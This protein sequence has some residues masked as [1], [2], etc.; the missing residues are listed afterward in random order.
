MAKREHLYPWAAERDYMRSLKAMIYNV[1]K[2]TMRVFAETQI[3]RMDS[4]S[5]DLSAIMRSLS[6][7]AAVQYVQ[8][9]QKLPGYFLAINKFNDKQWVLQVKAGTGITLPPLSAIPMGMTGYGSV[10]DPRLVRARFGI[11]VDVYRTEPWLAPLR[12]NWIAE[13]TRL[14]KS[15]PEQ[16]LGEV[17]SLIRR[18]AGAGLSPKELSK[19]IYERFEVSESRAKLIAADQTSKANADLTMY[20]QT[21]LGITEYT[22]ESSDDARVRPSHREAD[23]KKFS[24]D[25]TPA[26]T[27]AHPGKAIRCRC[28]ARSV[29]PEQQS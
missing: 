14:I 23:N 12:D 24:W 1:H 13:N 7:Y 2:E 18:N 20:R 5:D 11:G 22:W 25:K 19:Q 29:W 10:T 28:W 9:A 6:A 4:W 17:E 27:G 8:E 21:D 3:L 16:Y 15:I 26:I